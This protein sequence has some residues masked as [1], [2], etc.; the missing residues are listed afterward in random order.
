MVKKKKRTK[1]SK[2][3][4]R[5]SKSSIVGRMNMAHRNFVLFLALFIVFF[6]ANNFSTNVL[7]ENFFGVLYVISG[8][9]TLVFL[10]SLI[11]LFIIN[12]GRKKRR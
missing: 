8:A 7:F 6:V 11:V 2:A 4:S 3:A 12:D 9:L 1:P 10:I 5:K